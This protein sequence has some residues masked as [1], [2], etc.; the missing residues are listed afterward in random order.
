MRAP[1]R[2]RITPLLSLL[3]FTALAAPTADAQFGRRRG[4]EPFVVNA[5]GGE[6]PKLDD[7]FDA[8]GRA[9]VPTKIVIGAFSL[10]FATKQGTSARDEDGAG[11][12][13]NSSLELNLRGLDSTQMQAITDAAYDAF[14]AEARTAGF[15]VVTRQELLASPAYAAVRA[16]GKP[17]GEKKEGGA[18]HMYAWAPTGMSMNG[19]GLMPLEAQLAP[20]RSALGGLGALRQTMSAMGDTREAV[21]SARPMEALPAAFGGAAV[22]SVRLAV[23]FA[24]TSTRRGGSPTGLSASAGATLGLYVDDGNSLFNFRTANGNTRTFAVKQP[25]FFAGDAFASV[26]NDDPTGSNVALAVVGGV[27]GGNTSTR[28]SRRY[29]TINP[30]AYAQVVGSGLSR[31]AAVMFDAMKTVK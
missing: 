23:L 12:S 11:R 26:A 3:A 17:S 14:V 22:V 19:I 7:V 5:E 15:E 27:L 1:S 8:N 24:E 2:Y 29:V 18:V 21:Q 13:A 10:E 31:S 16:A 28:L 30:T 25:L 20:K 4:P 9:D 6:R